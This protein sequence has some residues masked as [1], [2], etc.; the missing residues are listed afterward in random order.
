MA[1]KTGNL[2]KYSE[3]QLVD[4]DTATGDEGCQGG[5]MDTAF[6]Y[7]EQNPLESEADYGYTAIGGKC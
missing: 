5:L 4:C 2:V 6:G 1:I 3:Q 7:I